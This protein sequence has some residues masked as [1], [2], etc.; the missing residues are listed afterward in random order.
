MVVV[1]VDGVPV[2]HALARQPSWVTAYRASRTRRYYAYRALL[3]GPPGTVA[4]VEVENESGERRRVGVR[5]P[6]EPIG[7]AATT[8]AAEEVEPE[9]EAPV[10]VERLERGYGYL[11][12]EGFEGP[13]FGERAD[14]ALDAVA[15][16][17]G[18]VLDLRHNAGGYTDLS[19]AVLGRF[20][21]RPLTVGLDCIADAERPSGLACTDHRVEPRGTIYPGPVAVLID[22]DVFSAGEL[23]AYGLC[24]TGRAR[25]FGR[26]TAGETDAV[27][28][29]PFPG[30]R[31]GYAVSD[32]RSV[33]GTSL[34]GRGVIPQQLVP[35][36][37]EDVRAG[38]DPELTAALDWLDQAVTRRADR[39]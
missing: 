30:G 34:F 6:D 11:W 5:R 9:I 26:P 21:A 37:L 16:L 25:C 19:R 13:T 27:I 31:V 20:F 10:Q 38:R 23:A 15:D 24:A 7:P 8:P 12:L 39:R 35:L 2:A 4:T 17:P 22:E 32:F 28:E 18:L 14:A 36:Q 3:D 1:A 33:D 29:L